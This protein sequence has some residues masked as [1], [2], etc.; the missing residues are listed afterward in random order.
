ME[1]TEMGTSEDGSSVLPS[2]RGTLGPAAGKRS[3]LSVLATSSGGT[4][5]D[6]ERRKRESE[7]DKKGNCTKVGVEVEILPGA[8]G[9]VVVSP[10]RDACCRIGRMV[11]Q[12]IMQFDLEVRFTYRVD[13]TD[14]SKPKGA[15]KE[16]QK[17]KE[18]YKHFT[19]WARVDLGCISP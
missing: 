19:F 14:G 15:E 4:L 3:R 2:S 18:E 12:L 8:T 11:L 13:D 10:L 5:R 9:E 16:T 17:G 7:V 1:G 6:K